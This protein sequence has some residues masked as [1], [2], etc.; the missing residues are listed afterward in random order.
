MFIYSSTMVFI[1]FVSEDGGVSDRDS[2][3]FLIF[4]HFF[5]FGNNYTLQSFNLLFCL[6]LCFS[7]EYI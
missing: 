5:F 6:F 2:S 4:P 3:F 7:S 1:V